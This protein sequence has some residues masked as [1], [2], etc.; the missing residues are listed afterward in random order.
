MEFRKVRWKEWSTTL[1]DK[2]NKS[3]SSNVKL[4]SKIEWF[5]R[6]H[7]YF[8]NDLPLSIKIKYYFGNPGI[9]KLIGFYKSRKYTFTDRCTDITNTDTHTGIQLGPIATKILRK[10]SSMSCISIFIT[11]AFLP[12]SMHPIHCSIDCN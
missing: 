3:R 11:H 12:V 4:I 2:F 5:C 1:S 9:C 10:R 8:E 7:I 6:Y